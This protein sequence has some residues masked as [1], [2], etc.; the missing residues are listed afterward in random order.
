MWYTFY[1]GGEELS[2]YRTYQLKP[3]TPI[4]IGSGE[5]VQPHEYIIKGDTLYRIQITNIYHQL[6]AKEQQQMTAYMLGDSIKLRSYVNEV[7]KESYGYISKM[8]VSE[9]VGRLYA[10][11]LRG[12]TRVNEQNQLLLQEFIHSM[13][14]EYIPGSTLK[15]AL[16][17]NVLHSLGE[18]KKDIHYVLSKN[19]KGRIVGVIPAMKGQDIESRYLEKTRVQEDPFKTVG[20]TDTRGK[21]EVGVYESNVYTYKPKKGSFERGIPMYMIC[22]KGSLQGDKVTALQGQIKVQETYFENPY[23]KG[24]PLTLEQIVADSHVKAR[25]MLKEELAFYKQAGYQETFEIYKQI[26]QIYSSLD[27]ENQM[28]LRIG[29]GS[30]MNATTFNLVNQ[31]RNIRTDPRSRMLVENI[32]PLGWVVMSLVE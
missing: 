3:L 1:G 13:G 17:G 29:R 30:G 2:Q 16:R 26:E 12:T 6:G 21:L 31:D 19:A 23:S 20:L 28:L 8:S 25:K 15:G 9:S 4:H 24:L 14:K 11:K 27:K 7:Y 18:D 10:S 22:A 5:E 32:Y